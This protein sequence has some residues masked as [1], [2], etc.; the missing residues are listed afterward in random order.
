MNG[1]IGTNGNYVIVMG[2][3]AG[4]Y[5]NYNAC[6]VWSH[7]KEAAAM[8]EL[9]KIRIIQKLN[10]LDLHE[11]QAYISVCETV[12]IKKMAIQLYNSKVK[13]NRTLETNQELQYYKDLISKY[14]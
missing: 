4:A 6:I 1:R 12:V 11:L 2:Y 7:E 3:V 5:L 10:K 8:N 14:Y 13:A 9:E